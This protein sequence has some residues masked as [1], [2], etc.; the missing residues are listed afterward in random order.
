[1]KANEF[2]KF[3]FKGAV[4]AMACDGDI[5][6][7]EIKEIELIAENEIYFM[8]FDY[9]IPMKEE[10]KLIK[11]GG[12][13]AINGFLTQLSKTDLKEKQEIILIEVLVRVIEADGIIDPNEVK[14]IQLILSKLNIEKETIIT[15]FPKQINWLIDFENYGLN[16]EFT[17]EIEFDKSK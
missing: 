2:Q 6:E 14:F 13:N 15:L 3:L 12:K 4:F 17:D 7:S 16:E 9:K 10:I 11:S 5:D 8:G 1:M